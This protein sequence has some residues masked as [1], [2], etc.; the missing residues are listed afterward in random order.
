MTPSIVD[1]PVPARMFRLEDVSVNPPARVPP[2]MS[3]F[4][5]SAMAVESPVVRDTPPQEVTGCNSVT[6][7]RSPFFTETGGERVIVINPSLELK[8][9]R[10]ATRVYDP[11]EV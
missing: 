8:G 2:E 9:P 4:L 11:N 1:G 7:I 10:S 5:L 6:P 3:P